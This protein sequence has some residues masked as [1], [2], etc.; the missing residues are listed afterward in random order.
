LFL[1]KSLATRST[2]DKSDDVMNCIADA[3]CSREM[4]V[5]NMPKLPE[6]D[7]LDGMFL[8]IK[9]RLLKLS[10]EKQNMLLYKFLGDISK[11]QN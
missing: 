1:D 6:M 11:E 7:A 8:Y 10:S 3:F 2:K 9:Q 5:I 4:P